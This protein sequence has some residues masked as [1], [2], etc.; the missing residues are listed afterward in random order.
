MSDVN[1]LTSAPARVS[2][3]ARF[4]PFP[5]AFFHFIKIIGLME[6]IEL[7]ELVGL[8]YCREPRTLAASFM[9]VHEWRRGKP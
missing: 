5:F 4:G 1:G 3:C 8:S 9:S 2:P 7:I 6:L